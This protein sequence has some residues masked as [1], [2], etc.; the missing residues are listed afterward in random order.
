MRSESILKKHGLKTGMPKYE[1]YL[2][3][4]ENE[5]L[6]KGLINKFLLSKNYQEMFDLLSSV[7][8]IAGFLAYQYAQDFNYTDCINF[9]DNE[10]CAAGPGT[11]RG[12]ER[13]F[14]INGK[15]DYE[16]I[17]KWTC[18]NYNQ[19]VDDYSNRFSFD[20]KARLLDGWDPKVPDISNCFCE[21]DKYMR[22]VEVTIGQ[23][24]GKR[25]KQ[26]FKP[27]NKQINFVFPPKWKVNFLT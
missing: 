3:I 19:L 23:G 26:K 24:G 6:N 11:K 10:F 7:T 16:A 20:I 17:V 5:I 22:Q 18:E 9:D 8:G 25:M 15:I 2:R 1:L 13:V 27:S 12:V 21:T 4:Y 14:D